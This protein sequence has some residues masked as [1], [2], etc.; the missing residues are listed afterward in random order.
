MT[1]ASSLAPAN[2]RFL[3]SRLRPLLQLL[4][5]HRGLIWLAIANGI[6]HQLAVLATATTAAW[7]VGRSVTGAPAEELRSGLV[8]LG[9]LV[10]PVTVMP[11]LE[12]FLAHVAAFRILADLRARVYDAFERLAPAYL[13]ERRSGELGAT[14]IADVEML[15]RF[16]AHTVSP[17]VVATTVPLTAVAVLG[18]IHWSLAAVL[19]PVLLLLLSVPHWLRREAAVQG[20]ALRARLG[21]LHAEIVDLLQGLRELVIFGQRRRQLERL[22]EQDTELVAA[23]IAHSRR[24]GIEHA[25]TDALTVVGLLAVLIVGAV[26]VSR[27]AISPALF[28]VAVILALTSLLPIV[29]VLDVVRDL[30]LAAAAA[31]RVWSLLGARASVVDRVT[32]APSLPIEPD[33]RFENVGFRYAP[34]LPPAARG[35][36]F[37]VR[38]GETVALVGH[39]GAGKSTLANLLLRLWDVDEGAIRIGGHDVRD[40]PQRTLR[41]LVTVVPQDVYLFNTPLRENIRLGSPDA[42]DRAVEAAARAAMAHSFIAELRDGYDT[43]AGELGGRLSGGQRQRIAIARALL[44]DAPILVM[45]E[46]V[47]DLDAVSEREVAAAI[48]RVRRGRTA[49]II[50]HRLSTIRTAD[51]VV[52]LEAGRVVEQGTHEELVAAN[53]TYARLISSQLHA[54]APVDHGLACAGTKPNPNRQARATP[55]HNEGGEH[56]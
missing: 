56:E 14:A 46:A 4:G 38:S 3:T 47:S 2:G 37:H 19:V 9:V 43:H 35:V 33:V 20:D 29:A 18:F 12:S 25:A 53:G 55:E 13:L 52:V 41:D 39:S 48:A 5:P 21:E 24:A 50:A 10:I 27:D 44:K 34:N 28:P 30:N 36:S 42:D 6:G 54:R 23:K 8:L 26:L 1:A 40:L 11:W 17:L 45:D 32:A 31:E 16:F 51:R 7:L 22:A 49:L 15:E